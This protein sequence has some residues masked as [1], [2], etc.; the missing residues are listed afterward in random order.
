ML[1]FWD[2]DLDL[3]GGMDALKIDFSS[4]KQMSTTSSAIIE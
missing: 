4:G 1:G 3:D 2:L